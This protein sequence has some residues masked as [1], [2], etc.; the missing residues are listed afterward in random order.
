MELRWRGLVDEVDGEENETGDLVE[1]RLST[2]S[3]KVWKF[4]L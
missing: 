2:V 4:A 3:L 1:K